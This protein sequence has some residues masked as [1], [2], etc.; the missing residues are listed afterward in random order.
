MKYSKY[1]ESLYIPLYTSLKY[2]GIFIKLF[3]KLTREI[4]DEY[5]RG[6]LQGAQNVTTIDKV[7]I[8]G[9]LIDRIEM[10]KMLM[11]SKKKHYK[12]PKM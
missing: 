1:T 4:I 9:P 5:T 6:N 3:D 2:S 10:Y 8:F 7:N 12:A 11:Q